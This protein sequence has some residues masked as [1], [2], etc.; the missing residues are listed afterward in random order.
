MLWSLLHTKEVKSRTVKS[1][2]QS[3]V[4]GEG[5]K[6]SLNPDLEPMVDCSRRAPFKI[7]VWCCAF[8]A[9]LSLII[10]S[11]PKI[12]VS[13]MS[14]LKT[15][16][17]CKATMLWIITPS[18]PHLPVFPLLSALFRMAVLCPELALSPL[19]RGNLLF[20]NQQA[21]QIGRVSVLFP[22]APGPLP[23]SAPP[24]RSPLHPPTLPPTLVLYPDA[25][26]S[27]H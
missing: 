22:W 21:L 27:F 16:N 11:Q 3:Y 14:S 1:V 25:S 19:H 26:T 9:Q 4:P 8:E 13:T 12:S 6:Q 2:V 23:D 24:S 15:T 20:V 7:W 5:R 10:L 18:L 17:L